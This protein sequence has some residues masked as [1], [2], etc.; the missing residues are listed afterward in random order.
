MAQSSKTTR[1]GRKRAIK[2][3]E[4]DARELIS[5]GS[6]IRTV[7]KQKELTLTR[8]ASMTRLSIS[9]L[10]QV[11]RNLLT[12][13]VSALK[14][15]ADVLG[16]PAGA[17]MFKTGR[18][19]GAARVSIVR[20]RERKRITLPASNISYELLSPDLRRRTS[21]LWLHAAPG[22]QSGPTFSHQGED[23]VV[24]LKGQLKVEVGGVWHDLASGDSI[25]FHSELP[26]R[27]CNRSNHETEAIWVS[28]PP[29]F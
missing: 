15:I 24:V 18:A 11:E 14:R 9:F 3:R 25:Y 10:S 23:A 13:S 1:S 4:E 22:A 19:T 29:S 17:L 5:L 2:V 6:D 12:P 21:I 8:L 26:H 16:I 20:R 28:A 7:R 27:W